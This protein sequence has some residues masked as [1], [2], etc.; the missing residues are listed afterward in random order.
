[1]ITRLNHRIAARTGEALSLIRH[2]DFQLKVVPS[3]EPHGREVVL[4]VR[5]PFCRGAVAYPGRAR[6]GSPAMAECG[7]C[8]VYFP[9]A[10]HDVFPTTEAALA[11]LA[12]ARRY[13]PA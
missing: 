9:V 3:D 5:C 8:D 1:M 6:D 4:G 11:G 2:L 12:H 10:D 13:I 7:R